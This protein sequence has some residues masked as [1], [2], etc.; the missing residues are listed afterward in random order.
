[1]DAVNGVTAAPPAARSGVN[2][3]ASWFLPRGDSVADGGGMGVRGWGWGVAARCYLSL[4]GR[5]PPPPPSLPLANQPLKPQP[6][7]LTLTRR[8]RACHVHSILQVQVSRRG[9]GEGEGCLPGEIVAGVNLLQGAS[10]NRSLCFC[11]FFIL[12]FFSFIF[13]H[14]CCCTVRA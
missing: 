1:M 5:S 8:G 10:P 13:R 6:V 14:C 4:A 12:S 9:E 3:P 7:T 11:S 2:G